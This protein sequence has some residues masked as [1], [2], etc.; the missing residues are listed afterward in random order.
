MKRSSLIWAARILAA[1]TLALAVGC[2][3]PGAPD[4]TYGGDGPGDG[5]FQIGDLVDTD[6]DGIPNVSDPDIDGDGIDNGQDS[7]VDGDG[8]DNGEDPDVDNDGIPN[9]A[10]NDVDGDGVVNAQDNDVDGDGID[11][12]SDPDVDGDGIDNGSDP[13]V[14]GDGMPNSSDPDIDGDGVPNAQD[15]DRDGDGIPNAQD[16]D[17]D[18]GAPDDPGGSEGLVIPVTDT[19]KLTFEINQTTKGHV[20]TSAD[21]LDFAEVRDRIDNENIELS[22]VSVVDFWAVAAPASQNFVAANADVAVIF[23][24]SYINDSG[25]KVVV[26]TTPSGPPSPFPYAEIGLL[27]D[28]VSRNHGLYVD[29]GYVDMKS[30][31][32]DRSVQSMVVEA[33][34]KLVDDLKSTGRMEVWLVIKFTGN[35]KL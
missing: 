21:V 12:G 34:L 32:K 13:D 33:D 8:I 25:D 29:Q 26:V 17:P 27:K 16:P 23:S 11:N 14:D 3:N 30:M 5:G 2:S 6:N 1:L 28:G 10:D 18:G 24:A 20:S 31:I 4:A 19:I 22:T 9:Q 7:D 15:P 35:K